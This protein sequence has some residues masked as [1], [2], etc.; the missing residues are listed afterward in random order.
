[1]LLPP[2]VRPALALLVVSRNHPAD[3][4]HKGMSNVQGLAHGQM[5]S[6]LQRLVHLV[7]EPLVVRE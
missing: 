6:R 5:H 7:A 4:L 2:S 1:M 3:D